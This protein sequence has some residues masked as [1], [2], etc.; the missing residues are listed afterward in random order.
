MQM[1]ITMV[2]PIIY[3]RIGG[4]EGKTHMNETPNEQ[5]ETD[6]PKQLLVIIT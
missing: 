3:V 5:R 1:Q 2:R 4:E 6:I